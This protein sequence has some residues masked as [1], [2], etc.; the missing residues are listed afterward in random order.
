VAA[1]SPTFND[2]KLRIHRSGKTWATDIDRFQRIMKMLHEHT[3]SDESRAKLKSIADGIRD[4]YAS[5]KKVFDAI[6]SEI[7]N[8]LTK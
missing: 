6:E 2:F 5:Q 1:Y 4:K 3:M 7:Q 8:G